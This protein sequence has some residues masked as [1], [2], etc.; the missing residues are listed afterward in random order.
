MK[1]QKIHPLYEDPNWYV[2]WWRQSHIFKVDDTDGKSSPITGAEFWF[3]QF[4]EPRELAVWL[5]ELVRRLANTKISEGKISAE[6]KK[7]LQEMP[8]YLHLSAQQKADL[9]FIIARE[10][11]TEAINA[12]TSTL[13]NSTDR[14]HLPGWQQ[15]QPQKLSDWRQVEALA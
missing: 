1:K 6:E 11:N 5:Y 10:L 9:A 3:A 8:P 12:E 13:Y 15:G 7:L 2:H 4:W 14:S